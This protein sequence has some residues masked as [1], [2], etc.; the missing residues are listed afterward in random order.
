MAARYLLTAPFVIQLASGASHQ[1]MTGAKRDSTHAAYTG[2][3]AGWWATTAPAAAATDP[4]LLAY[5]AV[6]P[7]GQVS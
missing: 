5:L 6:Y 4:K 7:D 2:T 1:V 3:P